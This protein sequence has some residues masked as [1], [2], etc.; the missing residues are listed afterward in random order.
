MD[1][2][3]SNTPTANLIDELGNLNAAIKELETRQKALNAE[4]KT[5]LA[6]G[7]E[8]LGNAFV[9]TKK[10]S[11]RTTLNGKKAEE[12]IKINVEKEFHSDFYTT[13]DV[14]RLN[15]TVRPVWAT[16]AE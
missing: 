15:V 3:F 13:T 16:A 5:R 7:E 2:I 14:T 1:T 12:F 6:E 9:A 4:L 10:T 8:A 11:P